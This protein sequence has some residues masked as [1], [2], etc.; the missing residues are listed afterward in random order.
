MITSMKAFNANVKIG[1]C[2]PTPPPGQDAFGYSY[3]C[4]Q[5][6]WRYKRNLMRW[7]YNLITQ[8][9]GRTAANIYVVPVSVNIDTVHNMEEAAAAPVNSRSAETVVRQINGVH[10]GTDG[11]KQM[12]DVVYYWIK[13][14]A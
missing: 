12:A 6:Q 2:T 8:F 10:P 3:G 5:P 4:G 9:D 14:L 1:I 13:N 11:Y 7:I